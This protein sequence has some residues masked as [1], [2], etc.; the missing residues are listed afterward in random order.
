MSTAP[1]SAKQAS[2]V[3][4]YADPASET[5][6]NGTQSAIKA[7]YSVKTAY[8]I[9]E[10]NLKKPAIIA[11]LTIFRADIAEVLDHD[12]QQAIRDLREAQQYARTNKDSKA[13]TAATRELNAIS[14]L[15]KATVI[16]ENKA[17]ILTIEQRQALADVA[18]EFKGKLVG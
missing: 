2:F 18:Q 7:G 15:H 3:Q 8:S 10:E 16:N 6:N 1:L 5:Y 9:S 17:P 11:A 14:N 12:R 13:L 4:N